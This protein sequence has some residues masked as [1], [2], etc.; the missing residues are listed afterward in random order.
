MKIQVLSD[1][2]LEF[3]DYTPTKTD[4]DVVVLAGDI[5]VKAQGVKWAQ[6]HFDCPVVYVLGNH[7]YYG[8]S[9]GRTLRKL[10][11]AAEGSNVH[12]LEQESLVLGGVRFLGGTLWTD[13]RLTGNQVLAQWDAQQTMT[14]FRKIR[15]EQF[16]KVRP[17]QLAE[18]HYDLRRFIEQQLAAPFEGKTVV[19][20]HHAPS[21]AS[22]HPRYKDSPSH[23]VASYAS[24]LEQ[25][26]D[27]E[28]VALWVHGHMHD[29][30]DYELAGTRVVC[31]PRGYAPSDLNEGFVPDWVLEV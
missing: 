7:E 20:T 26:F 14:D 5:H 22:I 16:R 24:P 18:K 8:G 17:H 19:V 6:K 9:L 4:A 29:S 3:Q 27:P 31:N 25:Y 13:Y 10:K 12:V 11:E 28:A 2:H 21:G 23:L 30:F 1:L 15:D